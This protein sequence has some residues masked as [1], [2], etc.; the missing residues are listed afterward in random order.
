MCEHK[1]HYTQMTQSEIWNI[2]KK[3]NERRK[4]S[5]S[6]H[7]LNRM[8]EKDISEFEIE[9]VFRDYDIIEFY[10][11]NSNNR[12][13]IRGRK[14]INGSNTVI[15]IRLD[16]GHIITGYKNRAND[17]HRTINWNN[18]EKD[19]DILKYI[20]DNGNSNELKEM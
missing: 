12:V 9:N 18:Y 13:L 16:N 6:Q 11:K 19:L 1:K 2:R 15:S 4:Y 8:A 14:A 10:K 17:N 20:L 5:A 3:I 7:I